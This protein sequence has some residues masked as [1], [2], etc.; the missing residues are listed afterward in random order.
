MSFTPLPRDKR[1]HQ[2]Y[3]YHTT[4]ATILNATA[5]MLTVWN[6]AQLRPGRRSSQ[7]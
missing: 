2:Q 5:D 6:P 3:H 4:L 1:Q 7:S